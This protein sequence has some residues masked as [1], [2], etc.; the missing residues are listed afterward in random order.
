DLSH[1]RK[2][3][4]RR[5]VLAFVEQLYHRNRE[6]MMLVVDEADLFAPQR[7]VKGA[8][9]LQGAMEDLVRRGRVRGI[10]CCL[11]TQR[12]ASLHKDALSQC[13]VLVAHRLVGAHDRKAVD[14]WIE[15]QGDRERS[16][17]MMQ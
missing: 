11:I 4:A 6:A 1:M 17:Q 7:A 10:G 3:E 8:E 15:A 12:P 13:S 14:Q 16:E 9:R 2:A 5:F